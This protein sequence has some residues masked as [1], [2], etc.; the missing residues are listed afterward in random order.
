M[1]TAPAKSRK[2]ARRDAEDDDCID[3]TLDDSPSRAKATSGTGVASSRAGSASS[4]AGALRP[5]QDDD[6]FFDRAQDADDD[7]ADDD[8]HALAPVPHAGIKRGNSDVSAASSKPRSKAP[9]AKAA[10][11]AAAKAARDSA[12]AEKKAEKEAEK[13]S[14]ASQRAVDRISRGGY[15]SQEIAVMMEDSLRYAQVGV[16]LAAELEA[17]AYHCLPPAPAASFVPAGD[18]AG[19]KCFYNT[20]HWR[21]RVPDM[22]RSTDKDI[23]F[24]N[25]VTVEPFVVVVHEGEYFVKLLIDEGTD[26]VEAQLSALRA[27]VPPVTR[28]VYVIVGARK[29]IE[30]GQTKTARAGGDRMLHTLTPDGFDAALMHLYVTS[31]LEVKEV[32]SEAA[33]VEYLVGLTRAIAEMPYK[34]Q[35]SSLAVVTK[36]R[37]NRVV[38]MPAS[39]DPAAGGAPQRGASIAAYGYDEDSAPP[40]GS[41][42]PVA[43]SSAVAGDDAWVMRKSTKK[44]TT[45]TWCAMLQMIPGISETKAS[46]IVAVYPTLR[47]LVNIYRDP[48]VSEKDKERLLEEI[49]FASTGRRMGKVSRDVYKF[50]TSRDPD[51][52]IGAEA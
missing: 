27:R 8:D 34:M 39:F 43:S 32:V 24:T 9:T 18:I 1:L 29:A 28:V 10:E 36:V 47:S 46:A 2:V 16:A 35:P 22:A 14:R 26:G 49:Q 40:I 38:A 15:K 25:D 5:S 13:R 6:F 3:L 30:R 42:A 37:V 48:A 23:V 50:F 45:E 19:V 4:A 11:K 12:R 33:A 17:A 21:R 20:V 51:Q 31:E 52:L 44:N 41:A 7:A